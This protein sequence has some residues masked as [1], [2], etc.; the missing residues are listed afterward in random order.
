[1]ERRTDICGKN[2]LTKEISCNHLVSESLTELSA[3][4]ELISLVCPFVA[5]RLDM[6]M[7]VCYL[8]GHVV[9]PHRGRLVETVLILDGNVRAGTSV[10]GNSGNVIIKP[11]LVCVCRLFPIDLVAR[12]FTP[13][14][15][16]CTYC[17]HIGDGR[18]ERTRTY[19]DR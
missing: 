17:A 9:G 4:I 2:I 8:D 3:Y 19:F 14:Q 16:P 12:S 15:I 10:G 6:G 7:I 13:A 1:M 18:G 11:N 5:Q